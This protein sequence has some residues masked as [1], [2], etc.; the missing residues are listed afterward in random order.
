MKSCKQVWES[1]KMFERK[2]EDWRVA[3]NRK[4]FL[5]SFREEKFQCYWAMK[6]KI[7]RKLSPGRESS[8][9]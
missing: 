4:C 1:L 5:R 7:I 2:I 9:V 8:E 6:E 3:A